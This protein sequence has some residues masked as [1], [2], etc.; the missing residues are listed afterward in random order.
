MKKSLLVLIIAVFLSTIPI[1]AQVVLDGTM[2][3]T[4]QL[5]GPEYDIKAEYGQQAG[6]NLFHSFQHFNINTNESA[7]FSGPESV[8]NIISR[9]T[10]GN[11][12]WIDGT[13]GS[14]VPGAN[15][16]LLNPS[17]VLFGANAV[18]DIG[19]SFH[20]STAHFLDMG[21]NKRFYTT[22]QE[23]DALSAA[24]PDAFGFL[25]NDI[26]PITF[27][28][29][30][31]Y[32]TLKVMEGKTISVIGGDIDIK[33]NLSAP[34]GQINIGS[35]NWKISDQQPTSS[36]KF[37]VSSFKSQITNSIIDVSGES[38]GNI[39][40]RSGRLF[41]DNSALLA[42]TGED[43][44][45]IIDIRAD[46]LS[47]DNG[48]IISADT[49]GTGNGADITIQAS[50]QVSLSGE[51]GSYSMILAQSLSEDEDGGNAGNVSVKTGELSFQDGSEISTA[52]S[53]GGK[54]G[55]VTLIASESV[56]FSGSDSM[57]NS[58]RIITTGEDY[59]SQGSGNVYIE[60]EKFSLN[61]GAL[62]ASESAGIGSG[63]NIE[64]Y[65][66]E[67]VSF[68]G[69]DSRGQGS[70]VIARADGPDEDAGDAGKVIISTKDLS[71][72][73]G[74]WVGNTSS[75]GGKSGDVE[76]YASG[77]VRFSGTDSNGYASK[78]YTSALSED[79]FAGNAGSILIEAQD[80]SFRDGGGIT[81][82]TSGAGKGGTVT[83]QASGSAEFIGFN[84][85]GENSGT[86]IYSLSKSAEYS[87]GNSG[88]INISADKLILS[89]KGNITTSSDG[90]GNAGDIDLKAGQI[91]ISGQSTGI[92]AASWSED[93]LGG[94]AGNLS[95]N[96]DTI[97]LDN[98]A[99]INNESYSGKGGDIS[100]QA[101]ESVSFSGSKTGIFAAV[102][103]E[104]EDSG[105]GS[106][107]IDTKKMS[108][109]DGAGIDSSASGFGKGGD[110]TVN[111]SE[112]VE[113]SGYG[114]NGQGC[115]IITNAGNYYSEGSGDIIINTKNIS[116][117]HGA[118]I[119]SDSSG[120]GD[121]GDISIRA[122]ESV[123]LS[124]YDDNGLGSGV[125]ARSDGDDEDA[126]NAG[127]VVIST[128]ELS[129]Q[130][131]AWVG[132]TIEGGG[133]GGN[134]EIYAESAHF[135]GTDGNGAPSKIY[136]DTLS[137]EYD[138]KAGDIII[139][140]KNISFRDGSGVTA[141]TE[142]KG[143][144][145]SVT[146][147]DADSIII[148]GTNPGGKNENSG[149]FARSEGSGENTGSA[150]EIHITAS[151]LTLSEKGEISTSTKGKG[152]AG[153]INLDVAH[154]DISAGA[155]VSSES[156][157][158]KNGGTA[159]T[160][161]VDAGSVRISDNSAIT[162]EAESGGGGQIHIQA[163][164]TLYLL[165]S[166][167][168]SSVELGHEKGGDV[169]VGSLSEKGEKG[170]FVILNQSSIT[171][172]ADMGDGGAVFIVTE[173]YI[174]SEDSKVTASS[175]RGN[176]GE[177]KIVAPDIDISSGLTVLPSNFL[178]ASHWMK[179]PCSERSGEKVSKFV[180]AGTDGLPASP[181]ECLAS[182]IV[183][184]KTGR[185]TL[186][187]LP[188]HLINKGERFFIKGNFELGA[189]AFEELL[190]Y[191]NAEKEKPGFY[192]DT[193][194]YLANSYKNI[195]H[196]RKALTL[197]LSALPV[198]EKSS[199]QYRNALFFSTLGDLYLSSGNTE[200]ALHYLEK[201]KD[202]AIL[203]K[204]SLA[205]AGILNN[206]GNA[207]TLS[208]DYQ[209]ALTAYRKS[210]EL[211]E[212]A[213]ETADKPFLNKL[214]GK[215]LINTARVIYQVNSFQD[216]V[217]T[218]DYARKQ[219]ESLYDSHDKAMDLLALG[220]WFLALSNKPGL[221]SQQL[222][223]E[224]FQILKKTKQLAEK[225]KNARMASYA[226]GYMGQILEARKRYPE[227]LE[228]T[229]SAAFFAQQGNFP[230][231]L[232][233]WQWQLGRVFRAGGDIENAAKSYISAIKTLNP[234]RWKLLSEYR[235]LKDVFQESIRPVYLEL[236]ELLVKQAGKNKDGSAHLFEARNTME[237]LKTAELQDFFKDECVAKSQKKTTRLDHAPSKTAV[238]Y[239]IV[240]RDSVAILLT[241]PNSMKHKIIPVDSKNLRKTVK[242]FRRQLQTASGSRF[243]YYAR[244]LFDWLVRPV[245]PELEAHDI[246]TLVVAPDGV[247]RL[248]PFSAL[249]DGKHFLVEKYA[250][251]TI[252]ST[253]LTDSEPIEP[254]KIEILINGLSEARQGYSALANVPKELKDIKAIMGGR[255]LQ[256]KEYTTGNLI[257]EFKNNE[258]SVVHMATHGE[259]GG[260]A[261]ATFLLTYD[262]KLTMD[263]LEKLIS[264]GRF[265][266]K[267]VELLT[268]SACQTA[269]GD[270]RAALGLA[271]IAVRAGVRS[272]IATLWFVDDKATYLAVSEFYKH[273]K[274]PG[275][276]KAKALQAAQKKLI[277]QSD[278]RHPAYWAPFL[279]IGNWL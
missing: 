88:N 166:N 96:T 176:D 179:T 106:I 260:T 183:I 181:E 39:F 6:A 50:E 246:D 161:T 231:I 80:I 177:V 155:S 174:K 65:A 32:S 86:G 130:D 44:G 103:G 133:E 214:K 138:S 250:I 169:F 185:E 265:R 54:G 117:K 35:G 247:L 95:I 110:V 59:Y 150:G 268:L 18:L 234:V 98:G 156:T 105:G 238:I 206:T 219:I 255:V 26:A 147:S 132:N 140:A 37:Q 251:V 189:L 93:E 137:A 58:S 224:S 67:S 277:A 198:A 107:S 94:S 200:K 149:I 79:D 16:Y 157:S 127:K 209:K 30:D 97:S 63:G 230:E 259:F 178:D 128:K 69:Y 40:I 11:S 25:S 235:T 154:L 197:L 123:R 145:G 148:T 5:T 113:L 114:N 194:I 38:G 89:D 226:C 240:F 199:D 163:D 241:L 43:T 245:E 7:V 19:G 204:S 229:R 121:S 162:T 99:L 72:Q 42:E 257:K 29:N 28:G 205:L 170:K 47:L 242:R 202:T 213:A 210:L 78:V 68:S 87:G 261:K 10:G 49:Y 212:Q 270:E 271:G 192:M 104:Y 269:L 17:G 172:N 208:K 52:S 76:I 223:T 186:E 129:F 175:R 70:G 146:V 165:N 118:L 243:R 22:H 221:D 201:G 151:N 264:L 274:T 190:S 153:N 239:P 1:Q 91:E 23:L 55:N 85:H 227:A 31:Q 225:Y 120:I 207:H 211:I 236:A 45:G 191:F 273:L 136:T 77:S 15:L 222:K 253:T 139:K 203:A 8:Q 41:V 71:F 100:V 90:G 73:D 256:D 262:G 101:S 279:L 182:P 64:I 159:G 131:G 122:S 180:V 258:Y 249:Y 164:D 34:G 278:Y 216:A 21:E 232:Y 81:S 102:H 244:Q 233:L 36:F 60:T 228:M 66:S 187:T 109:S 112:F 144:G 134:V 267:Q 217:A 13:L 254:G 158:S 119:T 266:E 171:A 56:E 82:S 57:G 275:V 84:P 2:G 14:T 188:W 276:S 220:S 152:E 48:S 215:V 143:Q 74:A 272:A 184:L 20:V 12:S 126:G 108:L 62:I 3:I 196:H 53:G 75:G 237:L 33:R 141:S 125:V 9:V 4:G 160:I 124:G 61:N 252:P 92:F 116:L 263:Q 248:I 83:I 24:P 167:V 193:V 168:T 173:N 115:S 142:G 135:S 218:L 195:G 51:I 111:A 27:E 46:R